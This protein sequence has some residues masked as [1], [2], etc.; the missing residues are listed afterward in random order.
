MKNKKRNI[1]WNGIIVMALVLCLCAFTL[2][3][4]N[5]TSLEGSV[6]SVY[7]GIYSQEIVVADI[8]AVKWEPK[9]PQ[10]E[11]KNGFSWLA[12]EKG[13]FKDSVS[14]SKVYVF[15]DDLKQPKLKLSYKD[16]LQLYFNSSDSL[17]T[18]LIYDRLTMKLDSLKDTRN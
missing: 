17:E 8:Q 16:S 11:R 9:L 7:S 6:F 10:M 18:Q 2:H 13:I 4:K 12:K 1:F 14:G 5:W 15:V 3:Y